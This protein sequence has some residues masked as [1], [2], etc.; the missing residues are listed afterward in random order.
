MILPI[1]SLNNSKPK[2]CINCKHFI[3]DNNNGI[4]GKCS[5]FQKENKNT[6]NYLVNG[7][8]DIS[9]KEFFYCSTSRESNNMCGKE[10]KYYKKKRV[11]R[12][13]L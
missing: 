9:Q 2:F 5:L 3:P 7:I 13:N 12:V 4:Y 10:G 1:I 11:K 8:N 6:I